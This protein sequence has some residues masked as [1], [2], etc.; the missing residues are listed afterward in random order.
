MTPTSARAKSVESSDNVKVMSAVSP[1]FSAARSLP[2][3][4]VGAAARSSLNRVP[5][6]V[7]PASASATPCVLAAVSVATTVSSASSSPS[8]VGSTVKLPEVAPAAR[9]SVP[10]AA[11][12]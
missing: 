5:V 11:V 2:T 7:G 1:A 10:V 12:A 6:A 3:V 8:A 4:T 9:V